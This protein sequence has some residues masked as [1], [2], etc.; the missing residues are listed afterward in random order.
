[1]RYLITG[2]AGF[3]GSNFVKYMLNKYS[4]IEIVNLDVLNYAG[5]E[6]NLLDINN[7]DRHKFIRGDICDIS[8]L[9]GLVGDCDIIVNFAAESHVDRSVSG[10]LKFIKPNVMG[11]INL[12]EFAREKNI[13]LFVQISTDEV[14][15]DVLEG[16]SNEEHA[17]YPNNPYAASKAAAEMMVNAYIK[18]YKIPAIITRSSNN[19]GPCQYPEK[20]IPFF[21]IRALNSKRL[22]IHGNGSNIRDWLYVY[23]NCEAI[24]LVINKGKLGEVYNIARNDEKTNLQIAQILLDKLGKSHDLI[25]FVEDRPWNDLRY[26]LDTSKIK[27]LGWEPKHDFE[28]GINLTID[29]Y[30]RYQKDV[31]RMLKLDLHHPMN[32]YMKSN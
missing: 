15:G 20:I 13:K 11:T 30:Q 27:K 28:K 18:T 32:S 8:K 7:D 26:A 24:D 14:Y 2:G 10:P 4:D 6:E 21:I 25:H 17:L 29:W 31:E 19:Y 16:F 3:I 5:R 22:P 23:D 12:L 1:M 9:N